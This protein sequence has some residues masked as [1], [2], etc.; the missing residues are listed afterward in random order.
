VTAGIRLVAHRS[1]ALAAVIA[2][3]LV[4]SGCIEAD[5]RSEF[6]DDGSA[7]HTYTLQIEKD[8]LEALGGLAGDSEQL[9]FD[10]AVL[11]AEEL[12]LE[13]EAID[14]DDYMGFRV[15]KEVE[16]NEDI[17]A[18][19]GELFAG[20]ATDGPAPTGAVTGSYVKDGDDWVLDLTIDSDQMFNASGLEEQGQSAE[21]MENFITF[22]YTAVMPGDI[23]ETNGDEVGDNTVEWELPITGQTEIRA[24]AAG[25]GG[26][27]SNSS[28][29]LIAL[30][31]LLLLG[32][33]VAIWLFTQ[34]RR[35]EP[36]VVAGVAP[37]PAGEPASYGPPA[38]PDTTAVPPAGS[39]VEME[40]APLAEEPPPT[41]HEQQTPGF[42]DQTT[43]EVP[44]VTRTDIPDEE[45]PV[46]R[47]GET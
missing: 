35:P 19:F 26:G 17:G 37:P 4:L 46:R 45:S 11:Q 38:A 7:V 27:G 18:T 31:A 32:A 1:S 34:R 9:N 5:M 25:G 33:L 22:T 24:V 41:L 15:S 14:N 42:F 21:Q 47:P 36:A 29:I 43:T 13:A 6:R 16:D 30:I 28:I 44:P 20:T 39:A 8:S 40:S 2:T 3:A 10:D 23:R 12:G